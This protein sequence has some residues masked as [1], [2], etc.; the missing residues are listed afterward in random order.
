MSRSLK[1]RELIEQLQEFDPEDEVIL[2]HVTEHGDGKSYEPELLRRSRC[3][4]I[5]EG[6]RL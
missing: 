2:E 4:L 3:V 1:V 5:V 6:R